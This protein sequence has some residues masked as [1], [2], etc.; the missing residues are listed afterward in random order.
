[1][2]VLGVTCAPTVPQISVEPVQDALFLARECQTISF[3]GEWAGECREEALVTSCGT[4]AAIPDDHLD[5]LT[6]ID[7]L[8]SSVVL[9]KGTGILNSDLVLYV[10]ASDGFGVCGASEVLAYADSCQRDQNDRP[11]RSGCEDDAQ[12][13]CCC[14]CG[15]RC[16]LAGRQL[17]L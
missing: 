10:T 5:Q 2:L 12:P 7:G 14:G 11:V 6:L 9:P 17:S 4:Q 15:G 8:G 1:L 3:E 16:S 13:W